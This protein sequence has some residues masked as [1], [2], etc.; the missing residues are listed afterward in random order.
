MPFKDNFLL[1]DPQVGWSNERSR[2]FGKDVLTAIHH[3]VAD[4]T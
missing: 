2:I 3:V 1:P 4:L